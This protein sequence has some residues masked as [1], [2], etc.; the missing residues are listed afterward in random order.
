M[1]FS[2]QKLQ[3][4]NAFCDLHNF[5][6]F[7]W[8]HSSRHYDMSSLT[9][10][11][12]AHLSNITTQNNNAQATTLYLLYNVGSVY[13]VYSVGRLTIINKCLFICCIGKNVGTE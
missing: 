3:A 8:M 2:V 5:L 11:M 9:P 4:S 7:M 13:N 12:H 10:D 6:T 1:L